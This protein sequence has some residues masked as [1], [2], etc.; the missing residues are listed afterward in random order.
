MIA[1]LGH[2]LRDVLG[3]VAD[4]L[5]HADDLQCRDHLAQVVR[6]RRAQRD[7]LD[8]QAFHLGLQRVDAT[9]HCRLAAGDVVLVRLSRGLVKMSSVLPVFDQRCRD[10]RRRSLRHARGLL[11][12]VGDDDDGIALAQLVDQLLDARGGDRVERRAGLVHQDDF[13]IDGD[14]ARDAQALLL[15]AGQR[16]CR[17]S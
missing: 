3:I 16:R 11:H 4:A 2:A 13:G 17:C 10:G 15:A 14:G 9:C 6:Q 12:R 5:D 7:D 1:D 8:H